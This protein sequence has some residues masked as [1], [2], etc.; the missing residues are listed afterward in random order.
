VTDQLTDRLTEMITAQL[1]LQDTLGTNPLGMSVE[2]RV[3]YLKD[4]YIALIKELGEA[5]DELGWKPWATSRHINESAA[6]GELRDAWQFL[7]NMML[8]VTGDTPENLAQRLETELYAKHEV[9]VQRATEGYDGVSGKCP[10][11]RRDL[12]EVSLVQVH[13][14]GAKLPLRILCYS[15]N[16][17]VPYDV[18]RPYLV[19]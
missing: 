5:M 13:V 1:K 8:A 4:Q 18:A 16:T 12:A 11:C 14:S 2:E 6:F 17:E 7:T 9:N 15:C 10:G 19:D 3:A